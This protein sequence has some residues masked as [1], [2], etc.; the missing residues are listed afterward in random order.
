MQFHICEISLQIGKGIVE[1]KERI[2]C[3]ALFFFFLYICLWTLLK[4]K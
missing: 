4:R 2:V 3:L 1:V